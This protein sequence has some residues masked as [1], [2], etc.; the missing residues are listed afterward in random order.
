MYPNQQSLTHILA[1][2]KVHLPLLVFGYAAFSVYNHTQYGIKVVKDSARYLEYA[3]HLENGFYF[4]PHNFWYIGYPLYILLLNQLGGD[5]LCRTPSAFHVGKEARDHTYERKKCT[6]PEYKRDA[7]VV[8][9]V[10][11]YGGSDT[12]KTKGQA[13]E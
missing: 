6:E 1:K 7:G 13:E 8:C 3:S 11:E 9:Q 5:S 12:P 10:A 2:Q 4:D